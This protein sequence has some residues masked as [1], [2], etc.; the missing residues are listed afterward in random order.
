[1]LDFLEALEIKPDHNENIY[2]SF[3]LSREHKIYSSTIIAV[4]Q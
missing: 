3:P 1:M 4:R 2:Y